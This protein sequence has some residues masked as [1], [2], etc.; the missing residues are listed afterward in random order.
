MTSKPHVFKLGGRWILAGYHWRTSAGGRV[1]FPLREAATVREL[2]QPRAA[3]RF[4]R[5]WK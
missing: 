3:N 1:W 2:Q 5:F 4:S